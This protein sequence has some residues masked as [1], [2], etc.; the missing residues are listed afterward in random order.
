MSR[1]ITSSKDCDMT[2]WSPTLTASGKPRYIEIAEAIRRDINEGVLTA[3]DRL[4]SQRSVAQTL[5]LDFTTVSRGFAEATKQ[6]LIESFVGRGS[7]VRAA[8]TAVAQ[9]DPRRALEEDPMMNMPP[10][11][12][13]PALLARMQEGLAHV[14]ANLIP[15]LRYQSVT[16]SMPDR[17]IAAEWMRAHGL[18]APLDRLAITPGAHAS[19][20][21]ILTHLSETGLVV[22]CEE[23][24]YP[25]IRTIA[26]QFGMRL[27]GV[28]TDADGI[29]PEALEQ[30]IQTHMPSALYLNPTLQNPLTHTIPMHRRE[31]IAQILEL[32]DLPLI[33]DD[34]CFFVAEN[35][36]Q[37]IS[38]LIPDLGWHIA[39]LSKAFGAGLRL[40]LTT[41]PRGYA[42]GRFTQVLRGANVMTSP[43]TT[44]LMSRWIQDGTARALQE[45][46]RT[47]ASKR[48]ALARQILQGCSFAAQDHAYNIWLT[49]PEG[50][51]RADVLGR[52]AHR[53][54]GIMPSDAFCLSNT[55]PEALRICMGGPMNS[56]ALG[57]DLNALRDALFSPTW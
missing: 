13:D 14:S 10:E 49:L 4:P 47:A 6:G 28:R 26:A 43:I 1:D 45:F 24:T 34:A 31:E 35:A 46:V 5:G 18:Q 17:E 42:K 32:H 21:A 36:P 2:H 39:G 56:A 7:F 57:E 27:I 15:L 23:A 44:A 33:E 48:Q 8:T 16:G 40:A 37:P 54:I 38:E 9:P 51:G 3:G 20:Y 11:P 55:P 25:G 19:V 52:M 30:A 41:V 12:E 29:V 50:Q 53:Q 22:L